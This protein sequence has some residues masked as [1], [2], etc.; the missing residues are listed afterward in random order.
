M[1]ACVTVEN[2]SVLNNRDQFLAFA[3]CACLYVVEQLQL[4]ILYQALYKNVQEDLQCQVLTVVRVI[5]V[6]Q[7]H[8]SV[9]VLT[10]GVQVQTGL[11]VNYS[12]LNVVEKKDCLIH[13][14]KC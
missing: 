13:K 12:Y 1:T 7:L 11:V 9:F 8:N 3:Y 10:G 14:T 2:M 4:H 5:Y 6:Q